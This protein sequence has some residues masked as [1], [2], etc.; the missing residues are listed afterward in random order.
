M[1]VAEALA[2]VT[3]ELVLVRCE[4]VDGWKD[5]RALARAVYLRTDGAGLAHDPLLAA[6]LRQ[7]A[8]GVMAT[9]AEALRHADPAAAL[10]RL[11]Q[12]AESLHEVRALL[13][14]ALTGGV[15]GS[16]DHDELVALSSRAGRSLAELE[17]SIRRTGVA[18]LA[19]E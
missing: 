2:M 19:A 7:G 3:R 17:R 8:N 4:D 14:W 18:P 16:P 5:A 13:Y 15:I 11:G 9:I 12:A 10:D 6:A 1:S